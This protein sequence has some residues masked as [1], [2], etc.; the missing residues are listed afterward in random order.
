MRALYLS[1]DMHTFTEG[2]PI[3]ARYLRVDPLDPTHVYVGGM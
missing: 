1:A 2:V 3:Y